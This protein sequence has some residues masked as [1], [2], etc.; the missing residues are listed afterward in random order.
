MLLGRRLCWFLNSRAG[1]T[2]ATSTAGAA[3]A[4]ATPVPV[5]YHS[6][7][8]ITEEEGILVFTVYTQ[9]KERAADGSRK[10]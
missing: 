3:T 1:R 6:G 2:A 5:V 4:T 7:Y 9:T 8:S 10:N